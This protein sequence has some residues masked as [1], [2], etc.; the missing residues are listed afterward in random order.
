MIDD[1]YDFDNRLQKFEIQF[2]GLKIM[3][4]SKNIFANVSFSFLNFCAKNVNVPTIFHVA[5]FARNIFFIVRLFKRFSK[6][7]LMK[8]WKFFMSN[9]P[10]FLKENWTTK[11]TRK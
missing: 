7:E 3:K 6:N 11:T 9:L 4:N 10:I 1:A 2:A 5:R 8:N